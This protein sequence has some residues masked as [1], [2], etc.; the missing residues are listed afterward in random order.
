MFA[1][2][3]G[4]EEELEK[5]EPVPK[6]DPAAPKALT[7]T[8]EAAFSGPVEG[9]FAA[10]NKTG[11]IALNG[12]ANDA[13]FLGN[14]ASPACY[15]TGYGHRREIEAGR[16]ACGRPPPQPPRSTATR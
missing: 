16:G 9:P 3:G 10:Q 2:T 6:S 12:Q 5:G 8:H 15:F 4:F 11:T 7:S 14:K 13:V 1:E